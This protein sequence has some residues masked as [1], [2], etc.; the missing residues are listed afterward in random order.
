MER[1]MHVTDEVQEELQGFDAGIPWG[2]AVGENLLEYF[3]P[4]HHAVVMVGCRAV[5]LAVGQKTVPLVGEARSTL[6]NID[7]M[8]VVRFVLLGSNLVRPIR[9]RC[10]AGITDQ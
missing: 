5:V 10:E 7:K 8:P 6:G 2:I 9:D 3:Y 1:L 4:I